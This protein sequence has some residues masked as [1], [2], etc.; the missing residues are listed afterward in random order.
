MRMPRGIVRV[1]PRLGYL[2]LVALCL[3]MLAVRTD[4][5]EPR[6]DI[7]HAS[8]PPVVQLNADDLRAPAERE[9]LGELLRQHDDFAHDL[10]F[11]LAA[12]LRDRCTP[13]HA[14]ELA[15]MAVAAYLP[16]L[17]GVQAAVATAPGMRHAAYA[18]VRRL[19]AAAPCGRTLRIVIGGYE[20][21]FEPERYAAAFPDSYFEP[22]LQ[23][24]P[25]DIA[26]RDLG[27]RAADPC[28]PV[29]YAVLPLDAQRAWS[30]LGLRAMLRRR[31][32]ETC[33]AG[34]HGE[35]TVDASMAAHLAA[36][37]RDNL[38]ALPA[39]CR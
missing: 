35:T 14:H 11:L 38:E 34:L 5:V 10:L 25:P 4:D 17:D 37:L 8:A 13:A 24:P 30:C 9:A 39:M 29:V 27:G 19:A 3:A 36:G 16:V 1:A 20:T 33:D 6:P 12:S 15:R 26:D 18:L 2:V 23:A 31:L 22:S 28:T 32:R 21:T 7:A